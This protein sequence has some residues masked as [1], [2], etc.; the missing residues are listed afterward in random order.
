M[1]TKTRQQ[2][3]RPGFHE[4]SHSYCDVKSALN[5]RHKKLPNATNSSQTNDG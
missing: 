4:T 5:N 2:R 3:M 1:H